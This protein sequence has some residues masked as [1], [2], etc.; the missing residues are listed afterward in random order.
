LK[1]TAADVDATQVSICDRRA[2]NSNSRP[3]KEICEFGW[4][5]KSQQKQHKSWIVNQKRESVAM[6][7]AIFSI[8]HDHLFFH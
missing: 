2:P 4:V 5:E 3:K 1:K 7:A 8:H 6:A